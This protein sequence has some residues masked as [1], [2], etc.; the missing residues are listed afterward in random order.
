[1]INVTQAPD[2]KVADFCDEAPDFCDGAE[3]FS[4]HL[5]LYLIRKAA[6]IQLR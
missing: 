5:F 3:L 2:D 1:V 4:E 6:L